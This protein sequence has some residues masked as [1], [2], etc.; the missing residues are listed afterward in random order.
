MYD[1]K[2]G[3]RRPVINSKPEEDSWNAISVAS[4]PK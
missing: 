4:N 2:A 1:P 3:P